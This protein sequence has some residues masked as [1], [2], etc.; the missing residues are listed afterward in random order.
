MKQIKNAGECWFCDKPC[1]EHSYWH[2]DCKVK[3]MEEN[4]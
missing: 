4:K 2:L 3:W 1:T